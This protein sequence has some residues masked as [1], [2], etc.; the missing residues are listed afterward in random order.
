V[1]IVGVEGGAGEEMIVVEDGGGQTLR[2]PLTAVKKA[3]L[4]FNW[5]R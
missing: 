2:I 5:K 4:A 3:R 1:R